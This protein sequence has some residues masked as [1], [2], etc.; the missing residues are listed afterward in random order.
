VRFRLTIFAVLCGVLAVAAGCQPLPQPFQPGAGQKTANPLL[1]LPDRSVIVVRPVAGMPGDSGAALA[2]EM[3]TALVD[4]NVPA[5]TDSGNRSSLVLTGQAIERPRGA[6]RSE[7]RLIWKVADRNGLQT[8]EHVLDIAAR[9]S[10]WTKGSPNLLREMATK[11]AGKV[12]GIIQGPAITDQTANRPQ[13]TL[14]VWPIDGAPE[15]AGALLRAELESSLRRRA[16]RVTSTMRP[17]S[18]V[19]VGSVSLKPGTDGK[20]IL[21]LEW[22]V[23]SAEGRELGKLHQK[24]AVTPK[25]LEN[26]WPKIARSIATGAADGIGNVLNKVPE[27][28]LSDVP[29]TIK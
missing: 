17:D 4:R 6:A 16:L 5:F 11:S 13:R 8:G 12:A 7:I 25:S 27:S 22:A 10:A 1:N 20:R 29:A 23:M 21:G 26:D 3:A 14:H 9:K 24:N 2:R 18:I 19:I 15:T 28:A